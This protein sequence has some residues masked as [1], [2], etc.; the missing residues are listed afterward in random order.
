VLPEKVTVSAESV[1]D[2][3]WLRLIV[4]VVLKVGVRVRFR[5]REKVSD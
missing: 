1:K 5:F 2:V 3:L 4:A